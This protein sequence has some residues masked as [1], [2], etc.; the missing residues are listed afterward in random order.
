MKF[1]SGALFEHTNCLLNRRNRYQFLATFLGELAIQYLDVSLRDSQWI[2][3]CPVN[4]S[5]FAHGI[6]VGWMSPVM[7]QLQTPESPL[8][9]EVFVEE[10]SWIGSL[11][12]IGSVIGNLLAGFLQD[13][14]GRKPI[15]F[16]LTVP[17]VVSRRFS[18]PRVGRH[19]Y[20]LGL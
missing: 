19:T 15:M 17:Y 2:S 10:L 8:S 20:P 1:P 7:R 3:F 18:L 5:T 12:G 6:G 11:L 4:I 13:R 16:A 9:F 14:I